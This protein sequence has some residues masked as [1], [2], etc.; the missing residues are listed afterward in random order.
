VYH[1]KVQDVD[2]L[3]RRITA[4]CETVNTSD[5]AENLAKG[6]VQSGRLSDHQGRTCGGLLM[7]IKTWKLSASFSEEPTLLSVLVEEIHGFC[8]G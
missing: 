4:A 3:R 8:C 5:V 2:Q 1:G 7:N 6:G